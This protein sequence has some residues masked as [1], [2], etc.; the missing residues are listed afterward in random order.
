MK[1]FIQDL[2]RGVIYPI[3]DELRQEHYIAFSLIDEN[4]NKLDSIE[5]MHKPSA[6]DII[7]NTN[8]LKTHLQY[9][10]K[11]ETVELSDTGYTGNLYGK[12]LNA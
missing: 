1:K 6:G 12:K 5:M 7:H 8:E 2:I 11:I 3:V 4:G 10:F 9:R